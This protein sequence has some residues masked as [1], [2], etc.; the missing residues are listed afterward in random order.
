MGPAHQAVVSSGK[1]FLLLLGVGRERDVVVEDLDLLRRE[2]P[3]IAQEQR[4][5]RLDGETPTVEIVERV[6]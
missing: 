1:T 2:Y 6:V 3:T 4:L 5:A